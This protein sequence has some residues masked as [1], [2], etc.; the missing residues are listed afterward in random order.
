MP[1]SGGMKARP[2]V[3]GVAGSDSRPSKGGAV[4]SSQLRRCA[5]WSGS[6]AGQPKEGCVPA[7][8]RL[9]PAPTPATQ[10]ASPEKGGSLPHKWRSPCTGEVR[11]WHA[12][13]CNGQGLPD[14]T[15][16]V[17]APSST[18]DGPRSSPSPPAATEKK[19][20]SARKR[21]GLTA[22]STPRSYGSSHPPAPKARQT[23]G[24]GSQSAPMKE[25]E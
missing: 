13:P 21:P 25:R 5:A 12:P 23:D 20:P 3:G 7:K 4:G 16:P 22:G 8:A 14:A 9:P 17:T 10:P 24:P 1:K 15:H 19:L 2:A 18:A 6:T 11:S